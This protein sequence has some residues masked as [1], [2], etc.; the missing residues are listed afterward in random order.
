LPAQCDDQA[1]TTPSGNRKV[2]A[3][4]VVAL[5]STSTAPAP[6]IVA[7][8]ADQLRTHSSNREQSAEIVCEQVDETLPDSLFVSRRSTLSRSSSIRSRI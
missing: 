7:D 2:N 8:G 3:V 5:L 1:A 4:P 6:I